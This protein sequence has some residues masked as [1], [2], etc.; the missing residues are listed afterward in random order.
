MKRLTLAVLAAFLLCLSAAAGATQAWISVN[1]VLR[2]GPDPGY[3]RVM[4]IPAGSYVAVQGCLDDWS[5][6]D[7]AVDGY[8]GW[9]AA[10]YLQYDWYGQP[11]YLTNYGMRIGIPIVS[12]VFSNYWGNYYRHRPWY[13]DRDRWRHYQPRYRSS[14]RT[15]P[16][17]RFPHDRRP[18]ARMIHERPA[19]PSRSRPQIQRQRENVREQR[20]TRSAPVRSTPRAV[21]PRSQPRSAAPARSR[22]PARDQRKDRNRDHRKG[23]GTP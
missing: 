3:P 11:V 1:L 12:F 15:L 13:R 23:G 19:S 4:L 16:P 21:A 8:R 20:T 18:P 2:A 5:W 9:V 17:A 7:V 6:C 10:S 22:T 14:R